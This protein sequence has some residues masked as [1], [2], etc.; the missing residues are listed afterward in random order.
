MGTM[1]LC[2]TAIWRTSTRL[3]N[4]SSERKVKLGVG[5]ERVVAHMD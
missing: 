3:S 1:R 5:D 4:A 2:Q